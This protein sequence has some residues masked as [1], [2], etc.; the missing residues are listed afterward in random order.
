MLLNY[1]E[2]CGFLVNPIS[3]NRQ[4]I[5]PIQK[6]YTAAWGAAVYQIVALLQESRP[7]GRLY[8]AIALIG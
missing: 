6:K 7:A 8:G 5:Y 3:E 4:I 2:P 1:S